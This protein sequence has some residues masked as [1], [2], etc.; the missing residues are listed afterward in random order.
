[1]PVHDVELYKQFFCIGVPE[2][3]EQVRLRFQVELEFVQCLANPNYLNCMF[4][5]VF[6][7]A[8]SLNNMLLMIFFFF[9]FSSTWLLQRSV[10]Y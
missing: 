6:K 4:L 10:F 3:D 2:T 7:T 5:L 1:M 8:I 9:S